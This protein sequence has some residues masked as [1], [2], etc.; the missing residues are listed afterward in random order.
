MEKR[1][2]QRLVYVSTG[3]VGVL[4]FATIAAGPVFGQE[5][6]RQ[7]TVHL[8]QANNDSPYTFVRAKFEPGEV[9]DPWAVRFFDQRG[10]DVPYFVWDSVAWKVAREGRADW[11]NRYALLN[12]HP[13]NAPEALQMRPRRLEA[14]KKQLPELGSN[15][16]AQDEAAK[17]SGDSVCAALYL[18]RHR[19]AAFGKDKLTLRIYPE[20]Q[21][22]PK[23]RK[24]EG[25]QVKERLTAAAGDLV[26]DGLPDRIAVRWKGHELFQSAGFKIGDKSGS[27]T[28]F[29]EENANADPKR[30]FSVEIEEG[31]ITRLFVR[32][33]TNGR[34][35]TPMNWQCTW[36]LFPEGS[37]VAL[38]GFSFDNTEGYLGGGLSMALLE[39]PKEPKQ[40]HEPLW[41]KP[42]WLHQL[43][44]AG[45]VAIHQFTDTPL[46]VGYANNPFNVS[47]P[48][49]FHVRHGEKTKGQGD[50]LLELNWTYE[51]TDK[52]IYRLFHPRLDN[53]GSYDLAE[54]TDLRET[55]LTNGKL[56]KVPTDARWKDGTLIWPPERV[57][58]LEEALRLVKFE[59]KVDWLYR[60]FVMG[61]GQKDTE[62][63]SGVRNVLGAAAGWV[64][65]PFKEDEIAELVVRFSLRKSSEL[66]AIT[67]QP[68]WMVLPT[69]LGK[70]DR[71][72]VEKSLS[73]CA[74]PAENAAAAMEM[75]RKQMAA[76]GSPI[77]G[78]SKNGGEGWHNNPAY[79]AVD[80]PVSLRF[81]HHFQLYDLAKHS[82][83]EYRKALLE[84]ADFSLETLG[85]KPF[86]QDNLRASVR[87]LWPNRVVML[88]PL[89]LRAYRET[90]NEKYAKAARL[91]FDDMLMSSTETNPHGYFWAWG[92]SPKKSELFDPNYNIAAVDRGLVD[93]WSEGQLPVIGKE[94]ASRF[95]AA[96]ARYLALSGQF[97][98]TLET[99]SMTAV[100][101]HFPGGIPSGLGQ[102][103]LFLHDDFAFYRG[104][105][106]DSIRWGI[107]DDGGTVERREGRRN[108]HSQK[109]GSRGLVFW[110][111]GIGRDTPSPSK[112]ARDM[113]D[114]W[115]SAALPKPRE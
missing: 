113:L 50:G 5:P 61:V 27:K 60:Q 1:A 47:T 49:S 88:V 45:F 15:L 100:Q 64:D 14:A 46:T 115:R 108:L 43:G 19:V 66:G 63:E 29:I 70:G 62:A 114:H 83:A 109:I 48:A 42:W 68:A 51:L 104:L 13:G 94:K 52:R 99:D 74:D 24:V 112:T 7:L 59:P 34:A 93:F 53:D 22:E 107:I 85:G 86:D 26:L 3:L 38:T 106:A 98:D 69:A 25:K 76:G 16:A 12:H 18:V 57:R 35:D 23:Q 78:A 81:V 2:M 28:G 11:G 102:L 6:R 20:R 56:T 39:M 97:L 96:Q 101:S 36:W 67:Y 41:E 71:A 91:V 82:K 31:I 32:G 33:Q 4:F 17:R 90:G 55:L 65:R 92:F 75:I 95:V 73:A 87:T 103:A 44:D 110:A 84:W 40:V 80:V 72:S 37:Y 8:V 10:K 30:L 9:A 58:A 54:I 89:M 79:F 21:T 77:Q 111:Y 105:A